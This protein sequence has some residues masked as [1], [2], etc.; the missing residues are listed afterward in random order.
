M[1]QN[2]TSDVGVHTNPHTGIALPQRI[3]SATV[4]AQ[5]DLPITQTYDWVSLEFADEITVPEDVWIDWDPATETFITVGEANPDGLTALIKSTSVY[6]DDISDSTWHDGS[7][8][9]AADI[10]MNMIMT[11]A[12]GTEGSVV[13]D[14][15]AA[16]A[17]AAFKSSFRGFAIESVDPLVVTIYSDNWQPDAENNVATGYP[18]GTLGYAYGTAGWHNMAV[19]NLAEADEALA[20]TVDK[21]DALE[22]EWTNYIAGPSLEVLAGYLEQAAADGFIPFEATLGDYVSADDAAARYAN[23]QSF[24]DTYGHFWVGT[25]PYVLDTVL[26]VEKQLVLTHHDAFVDLAD[27]WD[28]FAQPKLATVELDGSGRVTIGDEAVFDVFV[29]DP[30]GNAYPADEIDAVKYLLYDAT[31]ALVEV[32]EGVLDM[33][34]HYIVTLSG[35]AT[36][37]LAAGSNTLEVAVTPIPAAVPSFATFEFVTE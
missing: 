37:A 13:F 30:D 26:S 36:G 6:A 29:S 11:F 17:L 21:A 7:A 9:S 31:G 32:G 34:G 16:G 22:I 20:Y 1:W 23:L 18:N 4:V 12:P 19:S 15:S 8:F 25:G 10:V 24:Y 33:D 5:S 2:A 28:G 35:D 3:A 27:K 14:E